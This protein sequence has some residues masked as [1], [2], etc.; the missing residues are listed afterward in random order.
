MS[1]VNSMTMSK[2]ERDPYHKED[3]RG[4]GVNVMDGG[5]FYKVGHV[6]FGHFH[7]VHKFSIVDHSHCTSNIYN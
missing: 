4:N 5:D 2:T 3:T 1:S 7:F 6:T